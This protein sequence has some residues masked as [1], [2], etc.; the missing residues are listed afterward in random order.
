[1][2]TCRGKSHKDNSVMWTINMYSS[3]FYSHKKKKKFGPKCLSLRLIR[4]PTTWNLYI[5]R[6]KYHRNLKM[7]LPGHLHTV[8][9][10]SV[11]MG[12]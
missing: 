9:F 6:A 4:H 1:M 10:A 2:F 8:S 7:S 11:N 3:Y 12:L 5:A